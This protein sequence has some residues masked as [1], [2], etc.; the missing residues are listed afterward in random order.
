MVN[1]L[2]LKAANGQHKDLSGLKEIEEEDYFEMAGEKSGSVFAMTCALGVA[3]TQKNINLFPFIQYGTYL[4]IAS[5]L[6]NDLHDVSKLTYKGDLLSKK[7]TLPIKFLLDSGHIKDNPIRDYYDDLI[8]F[9]ELLTRRETVRKVI[10][11]SR[12]KVY[13]Q[14]HALKYLNKALNLL[15]QMESGHLDK[16]YLGNAIRN[17]FTNYIGGEVSEGNSYVF[18]RESRDY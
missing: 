13:C 17:Y 12:V 5:Q 9:E 4:G 11:E 10:E 3:T 6:A 7:Y 15:N 8:S 16:Q 1:C 2:L 18:S 14:F